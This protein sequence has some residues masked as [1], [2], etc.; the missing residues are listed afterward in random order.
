MPRKPRQ[1][2]VGKIY[3][4]IN[5]GV[6]KRSIFL[7]PQD[8]SRFILG[9]EFFNSDG[10]FHLWDMLARPHAIRA[11]TV[12][13]LAQRIESMRQKPRGRIVDLLGFALMPNHYH[14]ILREITEG[15]ISRFM[16]KLGG[17]SMYFNKQYKRIGPLFQSRYRAIPINSDEQL[18]AIFAYVHT[19]PI[20]L[21]ESGWKKRK[22]NDPVRALAALENYKWSSYRDYIGVPTFSQTI[23]TEFFTNFYGNQGKCRQAIKDWVAYKAAI[24]QPNLETM[25]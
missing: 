13:A 10:S 22:V 8:Y 15:G 11:G 9:L 18:A 20:E 2:E 21:T 1:L 25:E 24:S 23:Q 17:Y 3:H 16:R 12:P 14:F 4:I 6:E 19:N 7:K 5:R